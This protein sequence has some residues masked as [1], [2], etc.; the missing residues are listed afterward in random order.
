MRF[1]RSLICCN[2]CKNFF[3]FFFNLFFLEIFYVTFF[4]TTKTEGSFL[5]LSFSIKIIEAYLFPRLN[6]SFII[7]CT[8]KISFVALSY[9]LKIP[10][11]FDKLF[12][13]IMLTETSF[14]VQWM[15]W[16]NYSSKRLAQAYSYISMLFEAS[17]IWIHVSK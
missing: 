15:H 16:K 9:P 13:I 2:Y 8:F 5:I 3:G 4:P 11:F 17:Q 6:K 14:V 12:S 10:M 1:I 7:S